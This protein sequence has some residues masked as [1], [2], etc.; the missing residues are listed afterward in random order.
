MVQMEVKDVFGDLPAVATDR[1]LL[2]KLEEGD[3]ADLFAYA[4]DPEVAKH[5]S[6]PAHKTIEDSREFLNYVLGLY[7]Q[8][9]VA[10]WG[11]VFEGKLVGTCGF[12]DWY[13]HSSWAEIGYALSS[14]YWGRGL[15]TEAVRAVISF[16]FRT[17]SLNRIQGRC[18]V[19][20][21]ASIRVMEKAGMKLEGV[22]REHVYS[23]GRFLDIGMYAILRREWKA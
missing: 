13:L 5:T 14:G 9:E 17:M 18:E 12:L 23:E 21:V 19:E 8:A 15:M 6:W 22:L 16:G 7:R 4:S 1:L 20:N 2:R 3:L 11:V 10:P